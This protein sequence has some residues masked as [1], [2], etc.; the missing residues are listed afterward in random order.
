MNT[1]GMSK[2]IHD[3]KGKAAGYIKYAGDISLPNMAHISIVRST[4]PHGYV[5]KVNAEKALALPAHKPSRNA[6]L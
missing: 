3:A 6:I 5:K 1:V 2:P 4:I